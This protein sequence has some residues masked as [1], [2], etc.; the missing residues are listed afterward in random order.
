MIPMIS[1]TIIHIVCIL[2]S[3]IL[4]YLLTM[5]SIQEMSQA[6]QA[7]W[8]TFCIYSWHL[9]CVLGWGW[10]SSG[11]QGQNKRL[12]WFCPSCPHIVLSCFWIWK[13]T[14]IIHL[15]TQCAWASELR[16]YSITHIHINRLELCT[17]H[18]WWLIVVV[19]LLLEPPLQVKIGSNFC[20]SSSSREELI[21]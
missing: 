15:T 2:P 20:S 6:P 1:N 14:S 10:K 7:K 17:A 16:K 11:W 9:A 12:T 19:G 13:L 3:R 5:T 21:F 18:C 8:Y 4:T